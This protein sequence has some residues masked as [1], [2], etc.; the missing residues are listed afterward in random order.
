MGPIKTNLIYHSHSW[1]FRNHMYRANILSF[2]NITK[3]YVLLSTIHDFIVDMC[4][5]LTFGT[6]ISNTL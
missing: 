3:C 4:D 1:L 2:F 5:L 6:L